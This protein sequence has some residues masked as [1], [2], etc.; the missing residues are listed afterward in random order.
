M[1]FTGNRFPATY[2]LHAHLNYDNLNHMKQYVI[3]ELRPEDF[4]RIKDYL[5]K[6][7]LPSGVTGVYWL[8][9]DQKFLTDV[10][11]EHVNCGPF[12]FALELGPNLISCEFL[13]RSEK[14]IKCDCIC[15]ATEKQRNWMI[16]VID[17]MFDSL[18]IKI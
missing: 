11:L 9:I 5:D 8:P 14:R 17:A 12:F 3:D 7:F 1:V 15:Y 16:A 18:K 13:V 10:Q 6:K 4:I 2:I